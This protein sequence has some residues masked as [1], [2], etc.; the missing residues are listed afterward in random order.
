VFEQLSWLPT[1]NTIEGNFLTIERFVLDYLGSKDERSID[2]A[3]FK[4]FF[5]P[6]LATFD[7]FLRVKML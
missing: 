4:C 7:I 2:E 3:T 1:L 5:L 6:L